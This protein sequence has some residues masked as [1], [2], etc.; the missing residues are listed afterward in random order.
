MRLTFTCLAF[1]VVPALIACAPVS[2]GRTPIADIA[3]VKPAPAAVSTERHDLLLKLPP[4]ARLA[5]IRRARVWKAVDI[6][7]A[8]LRTG[9]DSPDAFAPGATVRCDYRDKEMS[10][11]T[12]KFACIIPPDDELK[13]KYGADNGEVFAEVAAT[14]LVSALGFAADRMYPVRI[15]CRGCPADPHESKREPREMVVFDPAA[16]ERKLKGELLETKTDS[17]WAWPELELVDEAAGGAPRAHRD[18]LKLLAVLLQHGD[19]KAAQQRLFCA[20]EA[21]PSGGEDDAICAEPWMMMQDLGVT[22]GRAN[23]F[24][25]NAAGSVNF[26][27]W[28][29]VPI[30]ADGA[31]CFGNLGQSQTGT[32]DRPRIGDAGRKFL[33]DLLVQLSD[34]QLH[35]LF[36]VARFA[37]RKTDSVRAATTA[38]WVEAFKAKRDQIVNR[39]CS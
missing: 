26:E 14:R 25:R 33:A 8:N 28:T 21:P 27:K 36:D 11:R 6:P 5:A 20:D 39:T 35:D 15:E 4:K 23:L 38:Q 17:G 29:S 13:V 19:N 31:A 24:N 22:F 3:Q 30:W 10:G 7:S 2:A 16:V 34:A 12:P 1:T 9:P 18:A 37:Q 32:L